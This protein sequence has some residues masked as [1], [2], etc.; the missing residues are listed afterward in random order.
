MIFGWSIGVGV[1]RFANP[2]AAGHSCVVA[3]VDAEPTM[4]IRAS[5]CL[6]AGTGASSFII[7]GHIPAQFIPVR[8]DG[9]GTFETFTVR[10]FMWRKDGMDRF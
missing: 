2:T 5:V 1:S 6:S 3:G 9:G 10:R 7:V 8:I 4:K